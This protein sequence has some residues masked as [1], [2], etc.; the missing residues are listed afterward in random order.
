MAKMKRSAW[1]AFF[2]NMIRSARLLIKNRDQ[3]AE[4]IREALDKIRKHSAAIREI[5]ADLETIIRLLK[6]WLSGDYTEIPHKTIV[7]FIAAILYY[8]NPFDVVPDIIPAVGYVDDVSVVAWVIK[9][10]KD[11]VNK[12]RD[13]EAQRT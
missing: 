10:F 13:W 12:F 5:L 4:V 9:S 7:I 1:N 6:S 11:E 8:L 3:L 2:K